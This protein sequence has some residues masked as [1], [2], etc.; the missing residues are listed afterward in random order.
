VEAVTAVIPEGLE[1]LAVWDAHDPG[2]WRERTEW[3]DGQLGGRANLTYRIDF[4]LLDAP[5]AAVHRYRL[6]D[7]G[8]KFAKAPDG[9][10]ATEPPVIVPLAELPPAHLMG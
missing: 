10:I 8:H 7:S 3:V 9:E 4:Y 2:P 5:F 1:P 6:D